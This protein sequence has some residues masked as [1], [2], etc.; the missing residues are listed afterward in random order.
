MITEQFKL[1]LRPFRTMALL[2]RQVSCRLDPFLA[3]DKMGALAGL[4]RQ[5]RLPALE[6][7][8]LQAAGAIQLK[9]EAGVEASVANAKVFCAALA[10]AVA[11]AAAVLMG[12]LFIIAGIPLL[13]LPDPVN[14][15][16]RSIL[17][18]SVGALLANVRVALKVPAN[19]NLAV[20][21]EDRDL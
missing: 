3:R 9:S 17:H 1:E 6:P 14:L 7:E 12:I 5:V 20:L 15:T 18:R 19:P 8:R 10:A 21:V 13:Q 16:V 11:A 4:R 2:A